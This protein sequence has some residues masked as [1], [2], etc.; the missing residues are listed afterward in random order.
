MIYLTL[1]GVPYL[2]I[3]SSTKQ[4]AYCQGFLVPRLLY[5]GAGYLRFSNPGNYEAYR[6]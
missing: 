1:F 4:F 5:Y 3:I 6:F 2:D